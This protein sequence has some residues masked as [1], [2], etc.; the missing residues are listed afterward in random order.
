MNEEIKEEQ[1]IKAEYD[2]D[3]TNEIVALTD[4]QIKEF[5]NNKGDDINE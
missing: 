2:N 3:P 1:I 4:E 5:S